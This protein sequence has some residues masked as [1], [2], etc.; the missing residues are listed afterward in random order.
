[1]QFLLSVPLMIIPMLLWRM[2]ALDDLLIVNIAIACAV[3]EAWKAT[4]TGFLAMIDFILSLAIAVGAL[5]L[6]LTNPKFSDPLFA[7]LVLFAF[8]DVASGAII[9]MR[10]AKRDIGF[11]T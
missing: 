9:S 6:A 7:T 3:V 5:F 1:M 4:S 10:A 2:T 8:A 11:N